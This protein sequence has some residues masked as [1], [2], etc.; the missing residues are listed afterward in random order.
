M[1]KYL[2]WHELNENGL[3]WK[4]FKSDP[5]ICTLIEYDGGTLGAIGSETWEDL[6]LNNFNDDYFFVKIEVP[7]FVWP[8]PVFVPE[9]FDAE[10]HIKTMTEVIK[11]SGVLESPGISL[12]KPAHEP[13]RFEG[14]PLYG[15]RFVTCL[16]EIVTGLAGE[17]AL[18]VRLSGN[19]GW[20]FTWVGIRYHDSDTAD[21]RNIIERKILRAA[22]NKVKASA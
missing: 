3:Y 11:A 21:F 9:V 12:V 2:E 10:A 16:L 7:T 19:S 17:G 20:N 5:Q 4:V 18:I 13:E 15:P 22:F 14:F 8:L 6:V 1:T